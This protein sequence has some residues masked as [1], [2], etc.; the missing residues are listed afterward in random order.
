[1]DKQSGSTTTS[2]RRFL[3]TAAGA[4]GV[5]IGTAVW[6]SGSAAAAVLPQAGAQPLMADK[7]G[8]V[9][10]RFAI[11]IGGK[12][13]WIQD[14]EGGHATSDVVNEKLGADHIIHKHIAGVKYEQIA[15]TAGFSMQKE[16][17][18]W[19]AA[20]WKVQGQFARKD[21]AIVAADFN[22]EAKQKRE[23]F[24]ALITETQI[25]ACD[26]SS[27]EPGYL[28]LKFAPEYTRTVKASGKVAVNDT[29]GPKQWLP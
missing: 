19:I 28:T 11:E 8:F 3:G 1:M 23:F 16:F 21:G 26:G 5:A 18:D 12:A 13:G 14:T 17:L 15:V 9:S 22:L 27:K 6:G 20:S 29:K 4:T 7:R 10:G 2:R 25:P 24:G